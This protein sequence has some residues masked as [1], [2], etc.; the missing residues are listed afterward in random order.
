MGA[1]FVETLSVLKQAADDGIARFP[2]SCAHYFE[3]GKQRDRTKR[4]ELS[5]TMLRLAGQ[6][7][8]APSHAIVPW[9]IR[10]ALISVFGLRRAVPELELFG[11]G[12]AHAFS[13]P[14][15]RYT[16]PAQ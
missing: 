11:A 5:R 10:Q 8:I 12:V 7:R 15:L 16:A 6:K 3:T 1:A 13:A 4:I 2:L 14:S 9:E